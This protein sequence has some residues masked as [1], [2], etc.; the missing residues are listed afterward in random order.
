MGISGKFLCYF[1]SFL[2]PLVAQHQANGWK[3]HFGNKVGFQET[4][5]GEKRSANSFKAD[6]YR[7]WVYLP[8]E[9]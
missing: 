6:T 4:S 1:G 2:S 7:R 3:S 8:Q 5:S 9:M